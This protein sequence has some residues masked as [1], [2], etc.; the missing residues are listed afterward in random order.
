MDKLKQELDDLNKSISDLENQI[1][2]AKIEAE[3]NIKPLNDELSKV[4]PDKEEF[5][6]KNDFDSFQVCKRKENYLK[7][8]IDEQ[9]NKYVILTDELYKL[10]TEKYYLEKQI[11]DLELDLEKQKLDLEKQKKLEEEK[12]KRIDEMLSQMD[13]V[14]NNYKRTHNLKQAAIDSNINPYTVEHWFNGGKHNFNEYYS[15][16]YNQII[17][18]DNY[19]KDLETKKLLKQMDDVIVAYKKT[20]SLKEASK[21]AN[22]SYDTVQYWYEWGSKGFGNENA[23]FYKRL[24]PLL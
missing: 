23:Y 19:F 14:L 4:K 3:N 22:V 7:F 8:K 9:W 20:S 13:D 15:N 21:I 18:I 12:I 5:V 16:F 10:K 17:E 24:K 1:E 11:T 6:L 2:E